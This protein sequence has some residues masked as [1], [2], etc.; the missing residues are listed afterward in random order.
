MQKPK[1]L[2]QNWKTCCRVIWASTWCLFCQKSSELQKDKK[3]LWR[4]MFSPRKVSNAGWQRQ[5]RL[6][7]SKQAIPGHKELTTSWLQTSFSSP[8]QPKR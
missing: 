5:K 3:A 7:N 6:Q 1:L 8:N 4:E 2:V